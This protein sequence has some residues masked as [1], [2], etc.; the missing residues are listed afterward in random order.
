MAWFCP[1]CKLSHWSG[2]CPWN[3][4]Q[5][6]SPATREAL[7]TASWWL[8][9]CQGYTSA[10]ATFSHALGRKRGG[11]LGTRNP[12]LIAGIQ[13]AFSL[14]VPQGRAVQAISPPLF[15]PA[16][17]HGLWFLPVSHK[18]D[19]KEETRAQ[20]GV[21]VAGKQHKLIVFIA[22]EKIRVKCGCIKEDTAMRQTP[23]PQPRAS[24]AQPSP[25]SSSPRS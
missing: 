21:P 13:A 24:R 1:D 11:L 7:G 18:D 3:G 23:M 12:R 8:Y 22:S 14:R 2:L 20:T 10:V 25:P 5:A 4:A 6:A 19:H 15:L 9:G 16:F 17:C